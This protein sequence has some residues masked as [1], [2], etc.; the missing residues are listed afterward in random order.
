MKGKI[1]T[2]L[3][4]AAWIA[5]FILILKVKDRF[6]LGLIFGAYIG[7]TVVAVIFAIKEIEKK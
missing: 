4:I 5:F 6:C 3:G 1:L 7:A 2:F